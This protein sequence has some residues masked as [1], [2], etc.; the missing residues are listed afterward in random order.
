MVSRLRFL[1]FFVLLAAVIFSGCSGDKGG[2]MGT[3]G[4]PSDQQQQQTAL[5][6]TKLPQFAGLAE[7][8]DISNGQA[9]LKWAA[10]SDDTTPAESITYLIYGGTSPVNFDTKW[11]FDTKGNLTFRLPVEAEK[12]Y[13]FAVR[14]MDQQ[15]NIDKNT[16]EKSI[17]IAGPV[18]PP[19]DTN[20]PAFDPT[21]SINAYSNRIVVCWNEA[22]DPEGSSVAYNVYISKQSFEAKNPEAGG[23]T[24]MT[25][26][27]TC[28]DINNDIQSG[29]TYF[30]LVTAQD[31]SGNVAGAE[32]QNIRKVTT[33]ETPVPV[34]DKNPPVFDQSSI[35]MNLYWDRIVICW[36]PATDAEGSLPINY[37]VY[38]GPDSFSAKDPVADNAHEISTIDS[39]ITLTD[40]IEP[41]STYYI[42]VVAKDSAGNISGA[43]DLNIKQVTT[44]QV[45]TKAPILPAVPNLMFGITQWS[46]GKQLLS[47]SWQAA[48]DSSVPVKY[49]V[50]LKMGKWTEPVADCKATGNY[51]AGTQ[52]TNCVIPDIL[53]PGQEYCVVVCAEDSAVPV[54]NISNG[55]SK[56]ACIIAVQS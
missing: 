54:P 24:R 29:G 19:K 46:L 20:P 50:V 6:D 55:I 49:Y 40:G 56:Q 3:L 33:T 15:G 17:K 51:C 45:D 27:E 34:G 12:V 11:N 53:M 10:A 8:T 42:L 28:Y 18:V 5:P 38:Y 26:N 30:I 25:T 23:A 9:E 47:V 14:A 48:A 36:K 35:A 44:P 43:V 21:I 37:V 16:V 2:E 1:A 13:Y 39:C 52:E 32:N 31:E 41:S 4:Q 22:T 7:V